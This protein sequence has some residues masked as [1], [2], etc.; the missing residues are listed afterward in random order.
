MDKVKLIKRCKRR[1]LRD[2]VMVIN[3]EAFMVG[4]TPR[5]VDATLKGGKR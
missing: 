1:E 3:S 5:L 4:I 2:L